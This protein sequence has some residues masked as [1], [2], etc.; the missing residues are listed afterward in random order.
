MGLPALGAHISSKWW[1][2]LS[3]ASPGSG[4]RQKLRAVGGGSIH[5]LPC[6]LPGRN[7]VF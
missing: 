3:D 1:R 6:A 2:C 5:K 7:V 4:G